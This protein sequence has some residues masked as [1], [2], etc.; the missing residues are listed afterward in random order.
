[1]ND[2]R[3]IKPESPALEERLRILEE[4]LPE[5]FI[6]GRID[7]DKLRELVGE[8]NLDDGSERYGLFW[9]G[10]HEA[11]ARAFKPSR[12]ALHRAPKEGVNELTTKNLIIEGEN[13]EVLRLLSKAYRGR[14]KMIYI[15]PPYNTG[16]DFVYDDKFAESPLEFEKRSGLRAEDG[17]ALQTN[18]KTTGRFHSNWLSMMYPRLLLSHDLL[19]PEGLVFVSIDDNELSNLRML[20]NEI[21]GE[22]NF[23]G[24]FIWK[25]RKFPDA[26]SLTG[27]STDHEYL[28]CYSRLDAKLAGIGRDES[29]FDNPDNDP[30]GLWMS[31]SIL[32][33]A[34]K[35]QRPNLHYSITDPSTNRK[36]SPPENNGWRYAKD[37]MQNLI[38]TDCILFPAKT[39]GRPREKK[40]R[41]DLLAE[42]I[43]FPTIIDDVFTSDGTSDIRALFESDVFDFPK[44]CALLKKILIQG[45][46]PDS[47]ILDFFAGSGTTAQAVL[48]LNEEDNGNRQFILVQVPES[49]PEGSE[50]SKAGFHV[51]TDITKERLRRVTKNLYEQNGKKSDRDRGFRVYKLSKTGFK[52]WRDFEGSSLEEYE[53]QLSLHLAET[54]DKAKEEDLVAEIMLREGFPLDS[55]LDRLEE[56]ALV[57]TRVESSASGH[58]LFICL[59]TGFGRSLTVRSFEKLGIASEDVFICRDGA[60]T[61]E[62][63]LRIREL[64]RLATV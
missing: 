5:C 48:E 45:S 1:M 37:R 58:R 64:C 52:S 34:T 2:E 44:P 8:Q 47:L 22:E 39:D 9:P 40:Y 6:E 33:L 36:Y 35:Q 42:N 55:T 17:T 27:V 54:D 56:G 29:K 31:R 28:L 21:Y 63:K 19:E 38:D 46:S 24:C 13:L 53:K 18:R 32:G 4:T 10:K 60:L 25:C 61:D 30:R 59:D 41:A 50:A 7:P 3:S 20:L 11:R 43:A 62:A 57:V 26:R 12:M 51:L 23:I 14:V 16:N 15:D 49:T